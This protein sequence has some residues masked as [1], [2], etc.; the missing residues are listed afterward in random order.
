MKT[1]TIELDEGQAA[2]LRRV[3]E[4]EGRPEADIARDAIVRYAR[5]RHQNSGLSDGPHETTADH[6]DESARPRLRTFAMIGI[7]EGPGGSIADIPE[8]ELLK[9]FGE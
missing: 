2:T 3:A 9:G 1:L 8:E 4:A 6:I 7:G 5:G